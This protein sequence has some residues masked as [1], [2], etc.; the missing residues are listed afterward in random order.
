MGILTCRVFP[1]PQIQ[2]KYRT[3]IVLFLFQFPTAVQ[4][5]ENNG[6]SKTQIFFPF[7]FSFDGRVRVVYGVCSGKWKVQDLGIC[8]DSTLARAITC[9]YNCANYFAR[10]VLRCTC[11]HKAVDYTAVVLQLYH[12]GIR[13]RL[14]CTRYGVVGRASRALVKREYRSCMAVVV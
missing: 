8:R 13:D 2:E 10:D 9:S 4:D 3:I 6:R 12:M 7:S 11:T 5:Y 14:W 1:S